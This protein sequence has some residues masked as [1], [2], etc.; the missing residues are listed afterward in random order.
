MCVCVCASPCIR[1]MCVCFSIHSSHVCA[2]FH[3][4]VPCVCLSV[5]PSDVCM[6]FC[7]SAANNS[8][9]FPFP[10]LPF[11]YPAIFVTKI[12]SIN[13]F[14][15]VPQTTDCHCTESVVSL[16]FFTVFQQMLNKP[17]WICGKIA[18]TIIFSNAFEFCFEQHISH[19]T[20]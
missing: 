1:G 13:F 8:P 14:Q 15:I 16:P 19:Y 6:P 2:P 5:H 17:R 12:Y 4:S 9:S 20:I 18:W 10:S 7:T 3:K 11:P